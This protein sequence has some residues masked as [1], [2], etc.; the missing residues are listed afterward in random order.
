MPLKPRYTDLLAEFH[1]RRQTL[2]DDLAL[3]NPD[4]WLIPLSDGAATACDLLRARID[5]D[6]SLAAAAEAVTVGLPDVQA[7][8]LPL[9]ADLDP[10]D[11]LDLAVETAQR[12]EQQLG[13]WENYQWQRKLRVGRQSVTL[14]ELLADSNAAY[15]Q[16]ETGLAHYLGG[17]ER[18]GKEGL[19]NWLGAVYNELMDSVA[20]MTDAE[21]S[22]PAWRGDWNTYQLLEHVWAWNE[23]ALDIA[24]HW[25]EPQPGAPL[26][27]LPLYGVHNRH[28]GKVYDGGDMVALADGIVTV[29]RKTVLLIDRADPALLCRENVLPWGNRGPL[30]NLI[31]DVYRHAWQHAQEIRS[32]RETRRPGGR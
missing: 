29:Y 8:D 2:W 30:C 32:Y 11:L 24:R 17:F 14:A 12:L 3:L 1:T 4:E 31:F 21:I 27:D 20:G 9:P 28:V 5:D 19:K 25:D 18:L 26:R 10:G 7:S 16:V 13:A 23:Q 15:G 6:R 22:G